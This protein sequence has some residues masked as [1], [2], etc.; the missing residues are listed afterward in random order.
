MSNTQALMLAYQL[1]ADG[2][3]VRCIGCEL[4]TFYFYATERLGWHSLYDGTWNM[5]CGA[6]YRVWLDEKYPGT[7]PSALKMYSP[8]TRAEAEEW[9]RQVFSTEIYNGIRCVHSKPKCDA[10]DWRKAS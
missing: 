2:P 4:R 1:R 5:H 6:C 8:R 7:S 10:C 3:I 9:D